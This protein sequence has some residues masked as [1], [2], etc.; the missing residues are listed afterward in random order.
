MFNISKTAALNRFR[1]RREHSSNTNIK[2]TYT[3]KRG[4]GKRIQRVAEKLLSA[5]TTNK[6]T[7]LHIYAGSRS[8]A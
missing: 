7:Q 3:G 8:R 2:K 5:V 6:T 1:Y 4:L